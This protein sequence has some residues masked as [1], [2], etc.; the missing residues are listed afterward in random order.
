M[1]PL[2]MPMRGGSLEALTSFFNLASRDDFV[3]VLRGY[4][5]RYE[6]RPLPVLAVRRQ[7]SAKVSPK[8]FEVD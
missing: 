5:R 7:G 2:P 1:L 6:M 3:L 8:C 4:L